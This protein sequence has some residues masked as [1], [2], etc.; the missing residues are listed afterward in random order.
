[1]DT[2]TYFFAAFIISALGS[3]PMGLI[4][5]TIVQRTLESGK[6]AGRMLSLGATLPEFIYTY[7]ALVGLTFFRESIA[8]NH[9]IQIG[10]TIVFFGFAC[11]FFFKKNQEFK[12]EKEETKYDYFDF[13]R[14]VLIAT[15]NLL[16]I[17]FWVLIGAWLSTYDM[18]FD[19]TYRIF[20]FSL[21]SALGALVIFLAYAELGEFILQR[22]A[23][24]VLYTN[25]IVASVFFALGVYQLT[26]LI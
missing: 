12:I 9:Y 18:A 25:K 19:T 7:I 5:L 6:K 1:M 4:T 24:I 2:L 11:F 14:G 21:G 13:G 10:A 15:M 16:I 22:M 8:V 26:Q 3:I 17:P 23:K 20:I